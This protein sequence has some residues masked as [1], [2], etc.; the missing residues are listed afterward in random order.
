MVLCRRLLLFEVWWILT[1]LYRANKKYLV[2]GTFMCDL[3]FYVIC[4]PSSLLT[5]HVWPCGPNPL[6][7]TLLNASGYQAQCLIFVR[8]RQ[9]AEIAT[10]SEL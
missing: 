9:Q 6:R 3:W 8:E 5:F 1:L 10:S 2:C 7:T 4:G